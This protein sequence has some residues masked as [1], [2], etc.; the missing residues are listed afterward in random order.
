MTATEQLPERN[1]LSQN[2][3]Y[4]VMVSWRRPTSNYSTNIATHSS[5]TEVDRAIFILSSSSSSSSSVHAD[6]PSRGG[7]V[8][9]Y[10]KDLHQPSLTTLF[11]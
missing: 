3:K 9:V 5:L 1:R 6:S 11:L 4:L 8:V 10:V 2:H 7:D